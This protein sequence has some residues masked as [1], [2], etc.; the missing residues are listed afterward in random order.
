[1]PSGQRCVLDAPSTWL[2][3]IGL[4]PSRA[5]TNLRSV[6]A[7]H[8]GT[9]SLPRVG[10]KQRTTRLRDFQLGIVLQNIVQPESHSRAIENDPQLRR[11]AQVVR[12][13]RSPMGRP[14]NQDH[15]R[16]SDRAASQWPPPLLRLR[17]GSTGLRSSATTSVRTTLWA[18]P[19]AAVADRGVLCLWEIKGQ[20]MET[21]PAGELFVASALRSVVCH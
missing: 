7:F 5:P 20:A 11:A 6:P 13:P 2:S 17:Q 19:R 1:M 9:T 12:L 16:D 18:V 15:D 10:R 14:P 21:S 3:L 8:Q 4:L